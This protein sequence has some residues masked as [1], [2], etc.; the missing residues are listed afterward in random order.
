MSERGEQ[1]ERERACAGEC[2]AQ[3]RVCCI[4]RLEAAEDGHE[5]VA[6]LGE[7]L[8]VVRVQR[9]LQIEPDEL[10]Q[11]A[12]RVRVLRAEHCA[13]DSGHNNHNAHHEH[14]TAT[15]KNRRA[16]ARQPIP[17]PI[18]NTRSKSDAIAICL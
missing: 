6:D 5:E 13:C 12:V 4:P 15:E 14:R 17:E 11:V 18:V 2:G 10:S 8:V 3:V 16:Q 1:H 9:H 7:R